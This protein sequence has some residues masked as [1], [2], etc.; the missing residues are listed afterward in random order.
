M[1]YLGTSDLPIYR[2]DK[3]QST[4]NLAYLIMDWNERD[5]V[6]VPDGADAL[7]EQI[8]EVWHEKTHNNEAMMRN[9]LVSELDY[10]ERRLFVVSVLIHSINE[11]NKVDFGIELNGWGFR[12]NA[13]KT[14]KSQLKNLNKQVR[15]AK[16]KIGLKQSELEQMDSGQA[17][18]G[19][20]KQK[21]KLERALGLKIDIKT[22]A[23][24]EWL[25]L[26][27][28]LIELNENGKRNTHNK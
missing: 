7:W 13:K 17:P 25:A 28:E 6:K 3:I 18:M 26:Y 15:A 16:T 23:V 14:V 21:I 8:Q 27:D 5:E 9:A 4:S 1:L 20:L 10:L 24:D 12:F 22:T 2:F 19:I 11:S